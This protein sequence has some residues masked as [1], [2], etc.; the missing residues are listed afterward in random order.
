LQRLLATPSNLLAHHVR[1]LQQ[2]GVVSRHRSEADRRRI[3]DPIE[4]G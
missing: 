1:V 3:L 2:A 4:R